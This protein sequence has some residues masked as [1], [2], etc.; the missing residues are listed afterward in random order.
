[1]DGIR[2]LLSAL[3]VLAAGIFW[4]THAH[5]AA[6]DVGAGFEPF[7]GS[8]ELV[9]GIASPPTHGHTRGH[10]DCVVASEGQGMAMIGDAMHAGA[11]QFPGPA[12]MMAFDTDSKAAE[13][14]KVYASLARERARPTVAHLPF[15]GIGHIRS[16]RG[17][18][19]YVP[20]N[21]SLP[22]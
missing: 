19:V 15:A 18:Y 22:R 5:A 16:E 12:I 14:R 6:L 17:G 21:Y 9:P 4:A 1:M 3:V 10:T 11:V 8:A 13:R 7:H 2:K 20:A